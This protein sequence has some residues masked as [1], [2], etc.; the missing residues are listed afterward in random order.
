MWPVG[1]PAPCFVGHSAFRHLIRNSDGCGAA[2]LQP[3]DERRGRP[4]MGA[5]LPGT[6]N[7]MTSDLKLE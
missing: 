6:E 2:G 3:S 7:S 1:I 5:T 4:H